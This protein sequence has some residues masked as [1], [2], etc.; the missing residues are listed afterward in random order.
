MSLAAVL[1]E[2]TMLAQIKSVAFTLPLESG[3]VS[4]SPD[5]ELLVMK[6]GRGV[7]K[8]DMLF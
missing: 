8:L 2:S 1:L 3:A 7:S 4:I 5:G 6:E